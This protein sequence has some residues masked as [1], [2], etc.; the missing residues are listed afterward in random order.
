MVDT[1]GIATKIDYEDFIKF[2]MNKGSAKKRAKEA[3]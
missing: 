3:I 1:P 2:G